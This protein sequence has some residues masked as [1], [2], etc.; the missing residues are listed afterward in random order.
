MTQ[1]NVGIVGFD[2]TPNIHPEFGAWGTTP[3][4]TK[5]DMPMLAHCLVLQQDDRRL[6]WFG[7]DHVGEGVV[8][9]NQRRDDVGSQLGVPRDRIIW[10]TSQTHACAALPG[11]KADAGSAITKIIRDTDGFRADEYERFVSLYVEAA[12]EAIG[13]LQP[14]TVWAGRGFCDTVSYNTRFPMPTGGCK[15]SRHHGEGLQSG[16]F[17]D[18]T[19]GLVRFE[20]KQGKALGAIF[21]FTC[22]PA[23][24]IMDEWVSPDYVGT[25][26]QH[27]ED[28]I[29]GAPAMFVQGFCGDIHNRHMFGTPQQARRTGARLGKA[30]AQAMTT[31]IPARP[32]PLDWTARTIEIQCQPPPS[33][34]EIRRQIDERLA[35]IE[36]LEHDPQAT[37]VCGIN[38]P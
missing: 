27:I 7:S 8:D 35:F 16:K 28:S 18:P 5:I 38:L 6:I 11:S 4:K 2:I 29:G 31:L 34:D 36:E 17:F 15:F 10:S 13:K 1:L 33:Q 9:T 19:V 20:D 3:L 14:A 24:M 22:H 23:T 21:N 12:R 25:A 30:A 32:G 37:W 26:R